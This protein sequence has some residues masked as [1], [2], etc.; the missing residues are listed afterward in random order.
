MEKS[1]NAF[2][3]N[4]WVKGEEKYFWI[5]N[6]LIS[7]V[8]FWA[9]YILLR[10]SCTQ[11]CWKSPTFVGK[12]KNYG[13]FSHEKTPHNNDIF[14]P[15]T[16]PDFYSRTASLVLTSDV[17]NDPKTKLPQHFWAPKLTFAPW[18]HNYHKTTF[19]ISVE[20]NY[21]FQIFYLFFILQMGTTIESEHLSELTCTEEE[22]ETRHSISEI[23]K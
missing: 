17:V 3:K 19:L 4:C 20:N 13:F 7:L 23:R 9:H 12:V 21:L 22:L 11:S 8:H 6:Q 1:S 14:G 10:E 16:Q 15:Q 18:L 2:A 5:Y